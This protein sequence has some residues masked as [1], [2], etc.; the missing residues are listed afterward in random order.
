MEIR[1][2]QGKEICA[3]IAA[4]ANAGVSELEVGDLKLKFGT[5]APEFVGIQTPIEGAQLSPPQLGITEE[6]QPIDHRLDILHQ[7]A[8]SDLTNTQTLIDNP[9]G[10]E[11]DMIDDMLNDRGGDYNDTKER[12]RVREAI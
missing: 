7:R 11:N 8:I 3:I 1:Y 12:R 4:C 10:F 5:S 9:V 2:L 6:Q